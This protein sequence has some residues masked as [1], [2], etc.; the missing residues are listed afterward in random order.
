[1][2]S[3]LEK[4]IDPKL[5]EQAINAIRFLA[6]D[7][8]QK[9]NSGH[10]GAPMGLAPLAYLLW[11]RQ[12]NYNPRNPKWPNRD[13]F[14]LSNGHAS[15]LHYSMLYLSGYDLS[16]DDLK[17]FRQ[18]GSRTPGHPEYGMTPGIETTTGP[19]GQG[20]GNGVGMAIAQKFLQATYNKPGHEII[21]HFIYAIAGDGCLQEGVASEAASIAGHL[22]LDNL[23]YFYD[24]NHIS[25]E[26]DTKIAF[27]EDVGKR[28]EAYGWHVQHVDDINDV[29]AIEAAIE[30][31]KGVK[32]QP[33]LIS[34]RSI[35]GYGSPN[36]NTGKVHGSALGKENV[37][38]A[39]EKLGWPLEPD[40]YVPGEVLALYREAVERGAKLEEE[41][42]DN[43]AA[44]AAAYPEEARQLKLGQAYELPEGWDKSLLIFSASEG[45][46][47]TRAA[48]G[49]ILNALAPVLPNLIGG[50]ADLAESTNTT[51]EHYPS[52]EPNEAKGGNY[53]GRTMHYGIREHGM[54]A[55][56]NG[57]T[58]Y[59][60]LRIYGATF[61]TF[62]DY[63]RG[64]LRLAALM[65][66]PSIFVFTHDSVGLGED[67]PTHQPVEHLASLRIIMGMTVLRPADANETAQAWKVLLER[68]HRPSSII[69]S[70][71]KL[72]ILDQAK[73]G[74]ATGVANGA[75]ILSEAEGGA[76]QLILIATGSEVS[77][78]LLGQE[79]LA[80]QG[81]RARVVSM[82]S[83]ELFEEQSDEYRESVLP[84]SITARLSIEAGS[85]L[86][87]EHYVGGAGASLAINH[88]G[89]SA[90]GEIVQ[91]KFGFSVATVVEL[92]QKLLSNPA[93][94]R[95]LAK[96]I[97][98]RNYH[99]NGGQK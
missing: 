58:V 69:L 80:K 9:A 32:G 73:Y 2:T 15:M 20:F 39:K 30:I 38:L 11:T 41:W 74:S 10:P 35:I 61:L 24:N 59:G 56:I 63:M 93:A 1:L 82:P 42:N 97:M 31:A 33:H 51:L 81:I 67:G 90:P 29:A 19:L 55:I 70:R 84:A 57:A 95:A 5:E 52:F 72:P 89:A 47:A 75:Y 54:G 60:G 76:P 92:S 91:E 12:M 77:L 26:G 34:V 36:Q 23:I 53:A 79:E 13:R 25:I 68:T 45:G 21:N 28:F 6:V 78:A 44:Y 62:A 65:E 48:S 87:W 66:I 49:K 7:A 99:L 96:E 14:V 8:V 4:K 3:A 94:A 43:W 71:Q 17:Q 86:G 98:N 27:T 46:I 88:F 22:E 18:W 40:F 85:P 50:S 16:L 83:W 64:S 37:K